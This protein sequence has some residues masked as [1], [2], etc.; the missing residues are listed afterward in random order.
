VKAPQTPKRDVKRKDNKPTPKQRQDALTS[1]ASPGRTVS[2]RDGGLTLGAC[3]TDAASF[4]YNLSAKSYE[5]PSLSDDLNRSTRIILSAYSNNGSPRRTGRISSKQAVSEVL[6][7]PSE[8]YPDTTGT[9][10]CDNEGGTILQ[11]KIK[12]QSD[13]REQMQPEKVDSTRVLSD[14]IVGN[15]CVSADIVRSGFEYGNNVMEDQEKEYWDINN[16]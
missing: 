5:P 7:Q 9:R 1:D 11:E 8:R 2:A 14:G 3:A 16:G 13:K 10:S 15:E 4:S 6:S 12:Q